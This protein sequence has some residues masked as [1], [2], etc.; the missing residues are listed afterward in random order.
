MMQKLF[1]LLQQIGKALM[2]PVSVLPIAGILLG[3]GS[4]KFSWIPANAEELIKTSGD[5]I[6]PNMSLTTGLSVTLLYIMRESGEA[7]FA[8]LPLLFA[9]GV[10]LGITANDGV[11]ALSAVVGYMVMLAAMGVVADINGLD[12]TLIMGIESVDTGVFGGIIIGLIA[13]FLFN[14]Y[15]RINLPS[16]LGFFAGKRFVPII[17]SFAAILTGT[18]LSFIWPPIGNFIR[19][20]GDWAAGGNQEI[21]V[22]LYGLVERALLPFG[23]H[24]I[25]NAP[26]FFEMGS[27]IT[28]EGAE[29]HGDIQRFFQGDM[30]A[31]IL[32]GG[33][34]FKMWG[35]PAAAIAIWHCA[36]PERRVAVG[37]LMVSA[38][39]TSFLTG[40]TEPIE[41]SFLFAAPALYA[42]HALLAGTAFLAMNLAGTHMGFTFS[43]GFIDYVL[44]FSMDT[45]PWMV[46]ILGPIYAAIYYAS[47][48][49]VITKFNLKTP[50]REDQSAEAAE[51]GTTSELPKQVVEALG[52]RDNIKSLDACIT[53]LRVVLHDNS[54]ANP[55]RLKALGAA[56][57]VQVGEGLQA[58]FGTLSEN[59]KSDIEAY[60]RSAGTELEAPPAPSMLLN[61]PTDEDIA[62][63]KTPEMMKQAQALADALGGAINITEIIP[64]ALTRILVSVNESAKINRTVLAENCRGIMYVSNTDLHII[65]N[66]EDQ[67][68]LTVAMQNLL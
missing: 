54:K 35:L 14:K 24:H 38:A 52:G 2:L 43:Q 27:Y 18:A 42:M 25:W 62:K 20:V 58:I 45:K 8:N 56:G 12:T 3:V 68:A 5:T 28:A 44:Y 31:G 67:A 21:A 61:G 33:F 15:F 1:A 7:I 26:F 30:T 64:A 36:K 41:F 65:V 47:F 4:S 10:A 16:Y 17:T 40:I 37:G 6:F 19:D 55:E 32:G 51:L 9:I 66:L 50:G 60:L 23:L 22:T 53:R 11:A 48:R 49:F 63:S 39:L 34:L 29:I 59:L 57:V 13:G 46:L